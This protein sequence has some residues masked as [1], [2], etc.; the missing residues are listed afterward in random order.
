MALPTRRLQTLAAILEQPAEFP[1]TAWLCA[2]PEVGRWLPDSPA[3]VVL[4]AAAGAPVPAPPGMRRIL[5]MDEVQLLME[6]LLRQ[7]PGASPMLR[8]QVLSR[9]REHAEF[10][11]LTA[12]PDTL[13]YYLADAVRHGTLEPADALNHLLRY[14]SHFTLEAAQ[15]I[16]AKAFLRQ[17]E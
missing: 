11:A 4:T 12:Q 17:G 7:V 16:L 15:H 3:A 10:P 8:V 1:P 13:A 2:P 14:F 6:R 5:F 9:Y